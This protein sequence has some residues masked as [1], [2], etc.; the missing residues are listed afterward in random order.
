MRWSRQTLLENFEKIVSEKE[1]KE[2]LDKVKDIKAAALAKKNVDDVYRKTE[3]EWWLDK[4]SKSKHLA[5]IKLD[6]TKQPQ[7][8]LPTKKESR[9]LRKKEMNFQETG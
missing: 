6:Y 1:K 5:N 9:Y 3:K 4:P 2:R 7:E 8:K